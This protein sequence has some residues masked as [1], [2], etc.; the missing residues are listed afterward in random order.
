MASA[1][2]SRLGRTH[3]DNI[4]MKKIIAIVLAL[5]VI[6]PCAAFGGDANQMKYVE[7][8]AP[9]AAA[10]SSN[11]AIAVAAYKGNA[12][13]VVQMAPA[14]ETATNTVTIKHSATANGAYVTITNLAGT[15]LTFS[16]SGP[17]TTAVQTA[18]IDLARVHPYVRAY[19]VH[20]LQTNAVSALLV[21]P[22]KSE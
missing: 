10:N 12:T 19:T 17:V 2:N 21:A 11:S 16:Q 9:T 7:L 5:A 15:A 13:V 1:G 3:G 18:A 4:D 14:T 22:M 20:A 8:L 6:L